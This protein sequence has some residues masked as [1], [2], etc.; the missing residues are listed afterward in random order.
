MIKSWSSPVISCGRCREYMNDS[1]QSY[2]GHCIRELTEENERL[3]QRVQ[4][5]EGGGK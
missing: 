4:E 2:C 3:K 1:E 5:L